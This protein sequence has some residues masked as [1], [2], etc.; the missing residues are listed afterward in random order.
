MKKSKL[1]DSKREKFELSTLY[2]TKPGGDGGQRYS[3]SES[4]LYYILYFKF[5]ITYMTTKCV[6][7]CVII[8][9]LEEI[10]Y[11]MNTGGERRAKFTT[12]LFFPIN[13]RIIESIILTMLI[14]EAFTDFFFLSIKI[15]GAKTL[16]HRGS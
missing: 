5:V 15:Q 4:R 6:V 14:F 8:N 16:F 13:K 12:L 3:N 1:Y 2:N 10:S 11:T 9:R 7:S